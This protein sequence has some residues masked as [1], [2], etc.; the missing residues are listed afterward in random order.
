MVLNLKHVHQQSLL[1]Q[2]ATHGVSTGLSF[3]S[4]DQ[5]AAMGASFVVASQ[6]LGR[7]PVMKVELVSDHS[8]SL[9]C[10]GYASGSLHESKHECRWEKSV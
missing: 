10:T 5:S 8:R 1:E 4:P 3:G 9:T 6:G 7:D 2:F